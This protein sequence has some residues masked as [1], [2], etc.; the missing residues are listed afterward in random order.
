[1][2]V[3]QFLIEIALFLALTL[4]G[5]YIVKIKPNNRHISFNINKYFPEDEIHTLRQVFYLTIMS[6]CFINAMYVLVFINHNLLYFTILDVTLSL[7]IASTIDK[8]TSTRKLLILLLVPYGSLSYILFN[9]TL[10]GLLAFIHVPV[11]LYFM[12]YYYKKFREYTE[13]NG[14]GITIILLFTI[15]TV[16]FIL[17]SFLENSNPLDAI[18]IVSNAF[19]SNGYTVLGNTMAGKINSLVLVWSGFIISG[20]GTATLTAAILTKHFNH[21]LKDYDDKFEELNDRFDSL[22][23]LI[24]KHFDDD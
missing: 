5:S 8:S 16:S 7:Y 21:K 2:P 17:T 23:K 9:N 6:A 13:S 19:T 15:I 18:V 14:L 22:E 12:I 11:F 10:I 24:E 20:V 1:M 3:V 4:I